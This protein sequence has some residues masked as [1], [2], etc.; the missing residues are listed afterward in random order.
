MTSG[1][2]PIKIHFLDPDEN[3]DEEVA[4]TDV[5]V[6][7]INGERHLFLSPQSFYSAVRQVKSAMPDL[8]EEQVERLVRE[9]CEFK[10]FDE[11]L[12]PP[13][14]VA[15]PVDLPPPVHEPDVQSP[16][17]GRVKKWAIA[18]ALIP[19]LAGSWMLGHYTGAA[20][21]PASAPDASPDTASDEAA[22][23]NRNLGP[24]PFTAH[25]FKDFSEAGK[26]HCSPIDNLE[27]ECTD[28][29]GM[30]M[31]TK[32]AT[33]PDST[34]FTFSY[35]RERIG[36]RIFGTADYAKTWSLQEGSQEL[37]PNMTRS[38]RYVLWSTDAARPRLKEYTKLLA[39]ASKK[40]AAGAHQVSMMGAADP[41][42]PRLAAL[43][44]GTLGLDRHDVHTILFD[45]R[46]A[47]V[48]VPVLM[49]ARAILGVGD[50]TPA[51]MLPGEEDIVALAMGIEPSPA[52]AEPDTV[53][54]PGGSSAG[55][56]VVVTTP[57]PVTDVKPAEI[58]QTQ[59]PEEPRKPVEPRWP[60][61]PTVPEPRPEPEEPKPEPEPEEP[62][63]EPEPEEPKP[64]RPPTSPDV[65][66]AI[67]PAEVPTAPQE[68]DSDETQPPTGSV[69]EEPPAAEE[70][71]SADS[72]GE[73]LGLPQ[74]WIAP[75]A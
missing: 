44:L 45:A 41:L 59:K 61:E 28:S 75:A 53:P 16:P 36:L 33:G 25:D 35:G 20:P 74:A 56:A 43:T 5:G 23:D 30:V 31:A 13:V 73:L 32:A 40:S 4:L 58:E 26:I 21:A 9:H 24:E 49:A 38:G 71:S 47:S 6:A 62:K 3:G 34:I 66:G 51:V 2:P 7:D 17:R 72:G 22:R 19:A 48:D 64:E 14:E 69:A 63:P 1:T 39:S 46:D 37:Y 27:A 12:G 15:P 65:P 8:P 67:P 57:G 55:S 42:P 52:V 18:A 10:D 11:L 60:A 68:P 70:P 29:D 54:A 50:R